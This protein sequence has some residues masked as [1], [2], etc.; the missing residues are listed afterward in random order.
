MSSG[1]DTETPVI[2]E[3]QEHD[4]ESTYKPPAQ[5]TLQD[6]VS[7]DAED[8]S[9]LKYKQALLGQ[10]LS[11]EQIVVEPDNPK[12]VI[13]KKLALVVEGRPDVVL[14]LTQDL[15]EI[16]RRTFTV[17]EGILYQIRIEFFVQR[18]IVTGLKYVQR[19]TRLG[20]PL[21]RMSQMVGSY[22]PKHE[23]QSFTTPKEE[24]PSGMLARGSYVA[25][26]L[27]TDDDQHE[28]LKWEWSFDIKKDWED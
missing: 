13:V 8:E 17:K 12:N 16:K 1:G 25:K 3:Q 26:S 4:E 7:A 27:F 18:E 28:H 21:E 23:L 9:L 19:I 22:A 10:A 6:I 2:G 24:M 20:A 15:A 5:K 11:G 14:D